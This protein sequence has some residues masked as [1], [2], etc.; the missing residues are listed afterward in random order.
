VV[1]TVIDQAHLRPSLQ[2]DFPVY[3]SHD[4]ALQLPFTPDV[5]ILADNFAPYECEYHGCRAFNPGTLLP[6]RAWKVYRP[7]S[8][9][10]EFSALE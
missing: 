3:W 7:G 10:V 4:H 5:L 9:T 1:K 8:H 2:S 6:D